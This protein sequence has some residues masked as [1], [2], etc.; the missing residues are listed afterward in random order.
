VFVYS[1]ELDTIPMPILQCIEY[2]G[3]NNS[4]V[5]GMYQ[6]ETAGCAGMKQVMEE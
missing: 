4:P 3:N 1:S 6:N 2:Q 5:R